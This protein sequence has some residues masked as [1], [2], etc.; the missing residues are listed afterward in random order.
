MKIFINVG[1][2][3][4]DVY[5]AEIIRELKKLD[6]ELEIHANGGKLME[7]AGAEVFCNL[8]DF[9]VIGISEVIKKYLPLM[10]ILRATARYIK[11]NDIKTVVLIDYPGFNLRLAK[12]LKKE[13]VKIVYYIMPQIWA[14][15]PGRIKTIKKTVDQAIVLFPFEKTLY[16]KAGVPVEYF[17]HPL[18]EAVKPSKTKKELR[19]E[20]CLDKR[21]IVVGLFPG[22]RTQEIETILPEMVKLVKNYSEPDYLLCR[23]PVISEDLLRKHLGVLPLKFI[24]GRAYDIMEA[25]DIAVFTSGTVTLEGALMKKPMVN[26]YKLSKLTELVFRFMAKISF[27]T[28]PNIIAGKKIVPELLQK[29]AN[30]KEIELELRR[31]LLNPQEKEKMLFELKKLSDS[32]KGEN[33]MAKTAAAILKSAK[34]A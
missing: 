22:S 11:E 7:A 25:S 19:E 12:L 16:E 8:V 28:L 13:K 9:S 5:G 21:R 29:H 10:K 24:E 6:P 31:I 34:S 17:G 26:V 20:F 33:V 18:Y 23:A 15:N 3:S 2:A 1:D 27:A 4:A 30:A 14:W 32:L